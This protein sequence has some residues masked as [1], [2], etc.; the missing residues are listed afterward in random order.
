MR[1]LLLAFGGAV[2]LLGGAIG[3]SYA[4]SAPTTAEQQHQA[5][6]DDAAA[7]LG[8]NGTDLA[9]ALKQARK[10][11]GFKVQIGKLARDELAVAARTIGVTDVKALRQELRGSTLTAVAQK[12]N[13]PPATVS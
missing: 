8:I 1:K 11:L 13:V 9:A 10:E 3:L 2:V 6:I 7:K 5:V 4:Q 12:H